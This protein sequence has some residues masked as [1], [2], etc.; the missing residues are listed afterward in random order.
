MSMNVSFDGFDSIY[1]CCISLDL[2]LLKTET[3]TKRLR[4]D[5][6]LTIT[7]I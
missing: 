4:A 6:L 5:A 7:I 1:T 2:I 3:D